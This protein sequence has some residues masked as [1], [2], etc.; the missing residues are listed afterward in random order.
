MPP[1]VKALRDAPLDSWVVLSEDESRIVATGKTF[2]DA[3][4]K[5]EAT[6]VSDPVVI[7]TPENWT[8]RVL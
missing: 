5:A 8:T 3:A 6:G 2:D 7:K 1:R 4:A